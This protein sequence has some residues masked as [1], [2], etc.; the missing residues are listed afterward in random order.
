MS[1]V[2]MLLRPD[3]G[4]A[5]RH[6]RDLSAGVAA[7]GHE[8]AVCGP[9]SHRADE[10]G[11][12]VIPVAM[13][14]EIS[15]R[16]DLRALREVLTVVRSWGPDLVHAHGSKASV[17]ARVGRPTY[18]RIPV[19]Y[20]PHGYPFAGYL[21]S[22]PAR[23]RY[24]LIER[25]LS[26]LATRILC[27]CEAERRLAC[28]VGPAARTT[29]VYNGTA[30]D[31]PRDRAA[32]MAGLDG[33]PVVVAVTGLRLGK[34]AETLIESWASVVGRHP[35]TVLVIAGDGVERARVEALISE[36][37]LSGSVRLLGQIEGADPVLAGGD[38]FVSPS[39]AESFPY[40]VLEAMA[41]GLAIVATDVGGTGEAIEDRVSGR[42]VGP[43]DPVALA[44]ALSEM[45]DDASAA[46]AIGEAARRRHR[47]LFTTERM[48]RRTVDLYREL[49]PDA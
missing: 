4:G 27:V 1:R 36:G 35:D 7:A 5:Y 43:R 45:L 21:T 29:V 33:R 47:E 26:R 49:T 31:P 8:V 9:L 23:R 48:V 15:P 28:S 22:E 39:W 17:Y 37:G 41:H 40:S 16:H 38:V 20:T 3:E 11:V 6:V 10:L 46:I 25:T 2:L 44:D 42:L 14:R 34:G 13:P 24:R 30:P 18:P 32:A 12:E 19:L